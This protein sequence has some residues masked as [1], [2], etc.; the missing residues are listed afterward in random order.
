MASKMSWKTY[1]AGLKASLKDFTP[2]ERRNIIIYTI[3]IM[4]YKFGLEAFNGSIAALATNRYDYAAFIAGERSRTFE[5]LGLLQGLN[6]A[7][8]CVGSIIVAPLVKRYP[9]KNV[10]AGAIA[11]FGMFSAILLIVDVCTGGKFIP[12]EYRGVGNNPTNDYSFYGKY[13]TDGMIPIYTFCGITYGMVEL[14]RR[15]IPRDIVGGNVQKLRK[16]DSMVGWKASSCLVC[17]VS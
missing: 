16:M 11:L 15:V 4:F 2:I 14:I 7:M 13:A 17:P 1:S 10:L 5:R 12:A 9:T 3:G 8:Q 6:Q